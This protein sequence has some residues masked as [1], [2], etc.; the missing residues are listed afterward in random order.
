MAFGMV[1]TWILVR[2]NYCFNLSTIRLN[3]NPNWA[4]T[5]CAAI[6]SYTFHWKSQFFFLRLFVPFSFHVDASLVI[7][8]NKNGPKRK[9][10]M[11][12]HRELSTKLYIIYGNYCYFLLWIKNS[13]THTL[14]HYFRNDGLNLLSAQWFFLFFACVCMC[15]LLL[16]CFR[17]YGLFNGQ[18]FSSLF[19]SQLLDSSYSV[20]FNGCCFFR[21]CARQQRWLKSLPHAVYNR[22]PTI[23]TYTF[24]AYKQ[25]RRIYGS[26]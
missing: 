13:H 16:L 12:T 21:L 8:Y 22:W 4:H 1:N 19:S 3:K 11:H 10:C 15:V 9:Y 5:R 7:E 26:K 25:T 17:L 20:E 24:Q 23:Q 14:E 18:N 6:P 2:V